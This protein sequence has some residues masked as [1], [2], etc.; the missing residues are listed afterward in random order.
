M[1]LAALLVSLRGLLVSLAVLVNSVVLLVNS[2]GFGYKWLYK[3]FSDKRCVVGKP[4][5]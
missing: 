4:L 5:K 3:K 2:A 1:S